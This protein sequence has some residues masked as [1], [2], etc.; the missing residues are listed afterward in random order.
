MT[1]RVRAY[2]AVGV[3]ALLWIGLSTARWLRRDIRPDAASDLD[4]PRL[5]TVGD[6]EYEDLAHTPPE[7]VPVLCYH[8]FREGVTVERVLRVL[9]A[10]LLSMPTLPDKEYWSTPVPEFERQMRWLHEEGY[11]T[12]TLDELSDWLEGRAARPER[13]VVLTIDDGDESFARLAAPVLHRYGFHA[14]VFVLTGRVG[15]RDWNDVD[16][17]DWSTLRR[18]Q[19]DG[20]IRVESH[21]H[22]MHTKARVRGQFVPRFLLAARDAD[23]AISS[24]SA[25]AQDLLASREAIRRELG[26]E[27]RYLAWPF[28]FGDAPVDSLAHSLGFRRVLTLSPRRN[29]RDFRAAFEP[30]P[31]DGLGRYAITARTSFR[32]FRLMVRGGEAPPRR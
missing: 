6:F 28:G 25:L 27:C 19:R 17:V 31:P 2:F 10:V 22:D 14:T 4:V 12:L 24:R 18:L 23:G 29:L 8:Y 13:A 1:D 26:S 20:T 21:T 15:E 32:L 3:L 16:F 5:F 30:D 11:R 9:G 7:G